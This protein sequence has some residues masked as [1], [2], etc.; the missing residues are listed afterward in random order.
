MLSLA[1][2][3]TFGFGKVS[4]AFGTAITRTIPPS[5]NLFTHL[6][7]LKYTAAGTAHTLTVMRPL[8]APTT[9][10]AAAASG[11]AVINV[12]AL[13][14]SMATNDYVVIKLSDGT[15]HTGVVSSVS[16]LAVTLTANLSAPGAAIGAKVWNLGVVG[17]HTN[18]QFNA[19]E[20][21]TTTYTDGVSSIVG[22]TAKESPMIVHS[23]NATATGTIEN[24]SGGYSLTVS[25]S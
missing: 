11:Q 7:N 17:D 3:K 14:G 23:N 8:A 12:A 15:Y 24:V 16:T 13:V 1:L 25:G 19:I 5:A 4:V 21:V 20:S 10:T 18:T 9:L 2:N 6:T 22:T